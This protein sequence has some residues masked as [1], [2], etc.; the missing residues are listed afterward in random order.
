MSPAGSRHVNGIN[1]GEL[2]YQRRHAA[3]STI[4]ATTDPALLRAEP[5]IEPETGSTSFNGTR[6]IT[7]ITREHMIQPTTA[8]AE[9]LRLPSRMAH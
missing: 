1:A 4:S 7:A 9:I 5:N 3:H 6:S 2:D 8:D